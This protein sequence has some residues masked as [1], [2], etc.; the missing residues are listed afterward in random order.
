MPDD[1]VRISVR[2]KSLRDVAAR[3]NEWAGYRP[4]PVGIEPHIEDW[5]PPRAPGDT[6]PAKAVRFTI[7]PPRIVMTPPFEAWIEEAKR[8]MP[9]ASG[10]SVAEW[11]AERFLAFLRH[12][13][14]P[15]LVQRFK[16][17]TRCR[18]WFVD[19]S[20]NRS[21]LRC[22]VGCTNRWWSR[23]QRRTAGQKQQRSAAVRG[24]P[25]RGRLLGK[26]PRG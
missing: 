19:G 13:T 1:L 10:E 26:R 24:Q 5:I 8:A 16:R 22:S 4:E 14:G 7:F 23:I 17:C 20:R 15:A 3:L 11:V 25:G 2:L 6:K 18:R 12:F 21:A 9:E